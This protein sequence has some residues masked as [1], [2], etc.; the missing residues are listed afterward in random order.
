MS[1][2]LP[3]IVPDSARTMFATSWREAIQQKV[4]R[5]RA[6]CQIVTG[7]TGNSATVDIFGKVEMED[8]TGQRYKKVNV[9]DV[10]TAQRFIYPKELQLPTFESRWDANSVAPLVAPSGKHA[11]A[12]AAA[13]G[14]K[15]DEIILTQLLG[16]AS[17]VLTSGSTPSVVALPSTQK[18]AKDFVSTGSATDSNLTIDKLLA[19]LQ[20]L[21]ENEVWGKDQMEAGAKLCIAVNSKANKALLRQIESGLG[22]KLM[23]KDFMPPTLDANGHIANF[24]GIHFVRTELVSSITDGGDVVAL[25][26]M[27]CSTAFQFN[28]WED[29]QTTIDVRPD[30][31]NAVQFLSQAR[32]GGARI[33][34]EGVVQ[35]A[36]V[37]G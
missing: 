15:V 32:V 31:S 35:I 26:P 14:R 1:Q 25:L 18:I 23:S 27:W 12:H 3:L 16:D 22:S 20:I 17:E 34:D 21:E 8:V 28:V 7:C 10:P 37:Q 36:A 13:Y 24:L 4:S 6:L 5:L 33:E 29:M 19:A 30:L 11:S 2:S 9:N